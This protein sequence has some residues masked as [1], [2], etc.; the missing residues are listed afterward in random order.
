MY[1]NELQPHPAEAQSLRRCGSTQHRRGRRMRK[2]LFRLS[3][4]PLASRM[5][6]ATGAALFGGLLTLSVASIWYQQK[7]MVD[8]LT[9]SGARL[10]DTVL[11]GLQ[12]AMMLNSRHELAEI[13]SNIGKAKDIVSIRVYNKEGEVMFSG[14]RA[15]VGTRTNIREEACHACHQVEPP[16]VALTLEE[17]TRVFYAE[18]GRHM[19]GVLT[20][21]MNDP[22][23]AGP[24]CHFHPEDKAVLGALD[25]VLPLEASEADVL[26]FQIYSLSLAALILLTG[27][28]AVHLYLRRFL[29]RPVA[30]LIK[31]TRAVAYGEKPDLSNIRQED[32][33]GELAQSILSMSRRISASR[34]E[35]NR[36]RDEY[37]RLFDQV[38]CAI[39]VQGKDLRLIRYN[40]RFREMFNPRPGDYC[41]AAY[42]GRTEKCTSC[43]VEKT[44]ESGKPEYSEESI[45]TPDGK[46]LHWLVQTSPV[47]D[48]TGKATAVMEMTVDITERKQLEERLRRSEEKYLAIFNNIPNSVFVLDQENLLILDCNTTVE[49]VYKVRRGELLGTSFLDFFLPEE[50]ERYQSLLKVFTVLNRA[51]HHTADGK[52]FYVD[53]MLSPS[54]YLEQPVFLVSTHDITDR[55]EAEQKVVQAGKMATLGE[56]A[57]G[58]AH[59]LNQPLTV[60]KS[61]SSFLMR[62]IREQAEVD[63]DILSTLA[64]EIDGHVDRASK[65]ITHMRNFGRRTDHVLEQV[66]VND[67]LRAATEFFGRQLHQRN[68]EM[69]WDLEE[70]LPP[71]MATPNLLE[72]VFTN[73]LLN[74]RDSI[75]ERSEKEPNCP[76]RITIASKHEAPLVIVRV[77][78]T[79]TGIPAGIR[80]RLFE[81][82][83]TTKRVGK[84][85]GLGLS[86]SYGLIKDFGGSIE[87]RNKSV[88]DADGPGAVFTLRFPST[89]GH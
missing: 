33:I 41:Y 27:G 61:A 58:V 71:I 18:D 49:R 82:F 11:G 42:K 70:K 37:Q 16:L 44:L 51:R 53:I 13:V 80:P 64:S 14:N 31:G 56:M 9:A 62:K 89:G 78:D 28:L 45:V 50:R 20:A 43:A 74:A 1:D 36:Q 55:L 87:V 83:F 34:A 7:H 69:V 32:E 81:P 10:A 8:S 84:G 35:I 54:E 63:P 38:P 73:L 26:S 88:H 60:I 5:L 6:I 48:E 68:I 76:R 39:T 22:G 57:T 30:E 25:I 72:Q 46:R 59:E 17:R 15:E 65:I 23:C 47:F 52:P 21:V 75:E 29:T 86:I 2:L 79:G 77:A 3:H 67:V 12:Y 66:Y 85:T 24:P 4:L 19:L 40:R